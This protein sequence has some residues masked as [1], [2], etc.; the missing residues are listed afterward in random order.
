MAKHGLQSGDSGYGREWR[1]GKPLLLVAALVSLLLL[2]TCLLCLLLLVDKTDVD[3][4]G[5]TL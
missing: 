5:V 2:L 4:T 1:P 3:G